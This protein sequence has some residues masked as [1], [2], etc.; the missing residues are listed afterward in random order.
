M[1]RPLKTYDEKSKDILSKPLWLEVIGTVG[2]ALLGPIIGASVVYYGHITN[3]AINS[4]DLKEKYVSLAVDVL[5]GKR[6]DSNTGIF[7]WA[8]QTVNKYADIPFS[9][10]AIQQLKDGSLSQNPVSFEVSRQEVTAGFDGNIYLTIINGTSD[11]LAIKSV[12]IFGASD[13]VP[14]CKMEAPIDPI[15]SFAFTNNPRSIKLGSVAAVVACLRA[16]ASAGRGF[17]LVDVSK[18]VGFDAYEKIMGH[19]YGIR[20]IPFGIEVNFQSKAGDTRTLFS[21]N[22]HYLSDETPGSSDQT[23]R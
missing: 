13:Q 3:K 11:P 22:L 2:T 23:V 6:D 20:N 21:A 19:N 4:D 15:F 9:D 10:E 18:D 7:N 16:N 8:A 5:K 12:A 1:T 17:H 14:P